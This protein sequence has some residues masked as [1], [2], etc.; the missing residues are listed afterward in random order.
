MLLERSGAQLRVRVKAGPRVE[1]HRPSVDVLFKSVARV[2]GPNAVGVILTGMGKDGV[3]GLRA[4]QERGARTIAQDEATCVVFGM[5]RA[6]IEAKVVDRVVPIGRVARTLLDF[7]QETSTT[8]T[9]RF[10]KPADER[11][12]TA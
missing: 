4:M 7:A 8:R 10:R 2:A 3:A 12:F 5:P 11:S 1:R 9:R 6:A